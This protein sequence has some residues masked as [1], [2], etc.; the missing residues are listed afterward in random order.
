MKITFV[1][2]KGKSGPTF[3]EIPVG[4]LFVKQTAPGE[5]MLLKKVNVYYYTHVYG[6]TTGHV[7]TKLAHDRL[8]FISKITVEV[9]KP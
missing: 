3:A 4:A 1:E 5:Y 2:P 9:I 7:G 6:D 8:Y